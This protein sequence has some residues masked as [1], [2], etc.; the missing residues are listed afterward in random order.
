MENEKVIR[1]AI[2]ASGGGTTADQIIRATHMGEL[3][4]KVI[5]T[6][7]I[8]TAH[9]IGAIEKA[10]RL[11][12]PVH[13]ITQSSYHHRTA[14]GEMLLELFERY[15]VDLFGQYGCLRKTPENVLEKYAGIN[16]HPADPRYFGGFGMYGLRP[17]R[18]VLHFARLAGI[19]RMWTYPVAQEVGPVYDSGRIIWFKPVEVF[20]YDTPETLQKRVLPTE[21]IV[22]IS[23]L[24]SV[25]SPHDCPK[26][27]LPRNFGLEQLKYL[28][29][30]IDLALQEPA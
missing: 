10:K 29:E 22:Q 4:D 7:L 21:H 28:P 3:D 12:I 25:Y 11:D 24:R 18:A 16:Q 9:G 20:P 2:L 15:E 26:V 6:C 13:V 5:V 23:A 19:K 17:H 14:Y 8:A 30:A 27:T 1:L